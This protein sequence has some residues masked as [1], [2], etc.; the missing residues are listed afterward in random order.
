MLLLYEGRS[1]KK[2]QNNG[3]PLIFKIWEIR[4]IGFVHNL[5]LS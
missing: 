5:I 2:L 1:I 3:V 4:N